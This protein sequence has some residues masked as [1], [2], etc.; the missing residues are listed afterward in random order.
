MKRILLVM[1]AI[2]A[3]ATAAVWFAAEESYVTTVK[4]RVGTS[5]RISSHGSQNYGLLFGQEVRVGSMNV[6]INAKAKADGNLTGVDFIV[7]CN[8]ERPDLNANTSGICAFLT[9][10]GKGQNT[11]CV[12]DPAGVPVD[13]FCA[14]TGTAQ[15]QLVQWEFVAPDCEGAA[16]KKP[17]GAVTV[18]C[19]QDKNWA[20]EGDVFIDVTGR[21][22]F[23][24]E[25]I[26]NKKGDILVDGQTGEPKLIDGEEIACIVD[27]NG[28]INDNGVNENH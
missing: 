15:S 1:A 20:L 3:V 27:D 5:L 18:P 4:A 14:L 26:C 11:L 28:I 6:E 13:S 24:K 22:G 21:H 12:L 9:I 2:A 16:Q 25:A 23:R 10:Q 17:A 19:S 8:Q 7:G